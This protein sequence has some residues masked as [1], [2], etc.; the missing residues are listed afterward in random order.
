MER[1]QRLAL[2]TEELRH[3]LSQVEHSRRGELP[4]SLVEPI[5]KHAP[6]KLVELAELQDDRFDLQD[7]LDQPPAHLTLDIDLFDDPTHGQQQ[8]TFYHGWYD[9]YQY[10][11]RAITCAENDPAL[12]RDRSAQG[13]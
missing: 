11:A 12:C 9:Q 3:L 8:L 1:R 13:C 4:E 5:L 7:V 2:V 10:L 6:G